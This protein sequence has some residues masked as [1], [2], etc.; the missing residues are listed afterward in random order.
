MEW[1]LEADSLSLTDLYFNGVV[2]VV[3]GNGAQHQVLDFTAGGVDVVSMVTYA[4]NPNPLAGGKYIYNN[5]A[6]GKT[7]HLSNVHL[8][9]LKQVG[10]ISLG[11]LPILPVTLAPGTPADAGSALAMAIMYAAHALNA[12]VPPMTF[13]KV[14]VD[15]YTLTSNT[16]SV[17]GFNVNMQP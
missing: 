1:H 14:H 2:T 7:V 13:T 12:P 10:T 11:G 3:D 17:P 4:P 6:K 16:L 8:H 15:Q 9:V 5:G